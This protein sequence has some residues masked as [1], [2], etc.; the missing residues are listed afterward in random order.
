MLYRDKYP[1]EK[2]PTLEEAVVLCLELKLK[3]FIDVKDRS[4]IQKVCV[5]TFQCQQNLDYV[6][7]ELLQKCSNTGFQHVASNTFSLHYSLASFPVKSNFI[8]QICA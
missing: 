7:I 5:F 6:F 2:I 4:N 8:P 3:M 1:N